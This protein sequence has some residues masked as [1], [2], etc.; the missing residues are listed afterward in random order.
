MIVYGNVWQDHKQNLGHPAQ[1]LQWIQMQLGENDG[2]SKVRH[3]RPVSWWLHD[4]R[5]FQ[6]EKMKGGCWMG[7]RNPNMSHPT[8]EHGPL[9]K[10]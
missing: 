1:M 8:P 9:P 10:V 2:R 3:T 5:A 6:H 4:Q 7:Q